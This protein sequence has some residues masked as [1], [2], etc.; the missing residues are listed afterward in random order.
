MN[1]TCILRL[2][3]YVSLGKI[4]T[5]LKTNPF[6]DQV[7]VCGNGFQTFLVAIV[8]ISEKNLLILARDA[9]VDPNR[10]P[11]ELCKVTQRFIQLEKNIM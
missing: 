2:L 11:G 10:Q 4:E 6:I 1:I 9:G 3:R 7:C 5:E 8:Q